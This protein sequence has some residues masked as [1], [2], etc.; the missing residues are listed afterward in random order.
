MKTI[1]TADQHRACVNYMLLECLLL[2]TGKLCI[3]VAAVRAV[4]DRPG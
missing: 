3:L 2:S 4:S 1:R